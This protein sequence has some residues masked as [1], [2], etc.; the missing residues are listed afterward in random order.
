MEKY[1]WSAIMKV[2]FKCLLVLIEDTVENESPESRNPYS[3]AP[4]W[5]GIGKNRKYL[6]NNSVST[7]TLHGFYIT[8][9][10]QTYQNE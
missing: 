5:K 2:Y 7:S 10:Y 1:C 3:T 4:Y 9:C 8:R 6:W